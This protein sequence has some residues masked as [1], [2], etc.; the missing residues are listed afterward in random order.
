MLCK[1]KKTFKGSQDGRFTET[2]TAGTEA[3]LS[4]Y[5]MSCAD[6]SWFEPVKSAPVIENKAV[7]SEPETKPLRTRIKKTGDN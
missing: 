5:L 4:D 1:I 7:I 6:K 3:D 2:F